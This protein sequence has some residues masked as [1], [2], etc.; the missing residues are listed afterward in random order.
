MG[1]TTNFDGCFKFSRQLTLNEKNELDEIHDKDWRDDPA[2]PGG[3]ED[4][5]SYYCQWQSDKQ[6]MYLEWDEGEKFYFYIEWLEWLIKNFFKPKEIKLNGSVT[7][8]GEDKED[9]GKIIV[10]N[11]EV[12]ILK[13]KV[14][15]V[16]KKVKTYKV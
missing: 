9:L 13:A 11:N 10:K 8:Q 15:Y 14:S 4:E 2:R 1:Y 3:K 7:W 12:K 16:Y 6:G 5:L